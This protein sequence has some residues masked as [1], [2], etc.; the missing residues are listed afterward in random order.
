MTHTDTQASSPDT[1]SS[2]KGQQVPIYTIGYGARDL[3]ALLAALK[4]HAIGYLIDV[5]TAPYSRF[6]PEFSKEA[7]EKAL[8]AR[9]IRY[10]FM[11]D[12][13]GGRPDDPACY[14]D[15]KVDYAAVAQTGAY[16]AGIAR[17][18]AA[19]QQQQR[20]V[21]MCSEGKPETCHRSKLIGKTLDEEGIPVAHID[22]T[23]TLRTQAEIIFR[24]TDGQLSLFGG[25]DFTSRKRYA[26]D[27]QDEQD[28][29][30]A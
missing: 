29:H 10:V 22:E 14:V 1:A 18:R 16:R 15:G 2:C 4:Q 3:P 6:K 25:H 13:L 5:R 21:L 7:L 28:D 11:G 30:D 8:I 12:S 24:L 26:Q 17:V 27:E 20:V 23:D 19:F 9:G